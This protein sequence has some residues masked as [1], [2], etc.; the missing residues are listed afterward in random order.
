MV[1]AGGGIRGGQVIGESDAQ[2][3]YPRVRPVTPADIHATIFTALGYDCRQT[4]QT[5]DGRP[6]P[7]TEGTLIAE[8]LA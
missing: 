5:A 3:A 6:T 4:Y 1:L 2:G 8:L 7:L